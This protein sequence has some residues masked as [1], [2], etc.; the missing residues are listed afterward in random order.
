MYFIN[1][2]LIHTVV[3]TDYAEGYCA[4]MAYDSDVCKVTW[5]YYSISSG[6]KAINYDVA[7]EVMTEK[8]GTIDNCIQAFDSPGK[9]AKGV[10]HYVFNDLITGGSRETYIFEDFET[11]TPYTDVEIMGWVNEGTIGSRAWYAQAF[12]GNDYAQ[13]TSYNSGE[14]NEMYLITPVINLDEMDDP[15]LKFLSAQAYW[16]HDGLTVLIST[17]FDGSDIEGATWDELNCNLAGE[18]DPNHAWVPSGII[19]LADYEGDAYIAFKYVGEDDIET[20]VIVWMIL[21]YRWRCW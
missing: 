11:Q 9:M 6:A 3:D 19:S 21:K 13:A 16:N 10:E 2:T 20:Q 17:D 15:R 7:E 8:K 18:D 14:V 4:V 12:S 1:G 5:D